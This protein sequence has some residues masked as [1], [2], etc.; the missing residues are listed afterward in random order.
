[1]NKKE[2][3][4]RLEA[5]LSLKASE[6]QT[7]K[8][9]N[10]Y[11]Q[12][13]DDALSIDKSI[14]YVIEELGQ[15]EVLS[16][17][18]LAG[19]QL[20]VCDLFAS[21]SLVRMIDLALIDIR[22]HLVIVPSQMLTITYQ[23]VE[24]Y[25][26]ELVNVEFKSNHLRV[27]QRQHR[28]MPWQNSHSP[29]QNPYLLIQLPQ[30]FKGKILLNTKESRII[31]DGRELQTRAQFNITSVNGRIEVSNF[32]GKNIT[33]MNQNGRIDVIGSTLQT[34]DLESYSGR[35]DVSNSKAS[36]VSCKNNQERV[37]LTGNKIDLAEISTEEGRIVVV[38]N[39]IDDCHMMSVDGR[40]NYRHQNPNV[41]LHLDILSLQGKI[42]IDDLKLSKG[43]LNIKDIESRKKEKQYVDIYARSNSGKIEIE[44]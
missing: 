4:K 14:Q 35:I 11:D 24:Q 22:V 39:E 40:I 7:I 28:I 21:E 42:T 34:M 10:Y 5:Q 6:E 2:Y 33:M 3:L 18:V 26:P 13:F 30:R 29:R 23:G 20:K 44:R 16:R 32:I 27:V 8:I 9:L 1:M 19:I 31:I 37:T 38:G 43:V 15:P 41:G 12:Y 36:Y 25:H 17:E